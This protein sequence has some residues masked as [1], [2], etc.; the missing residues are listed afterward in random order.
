M[1]VNEEKREDFAVA[2][3]CRVSELERS[4]AVLEDVRPGEQ[5]AFFA[6]DVSDFLDARALVLDAEDFAEPFVVALLIGELMDWFGLAG[7]SECETALGDVLAV[8]VVQGSGADVFVLPRVNES[9]FGELE[10][11]AGTY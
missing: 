11:Q 9:T 8:V 4:D 10:F 3:F 1:R 2:G 7:L 6:D 5:A